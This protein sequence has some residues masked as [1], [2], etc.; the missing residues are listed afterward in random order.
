MAISTISLTNAVSGV[1]PVA[2]GVLLWVIGL[3]SQP[4]G[5]YAPSAILTRTK[6]PPIHSEDILIITLTNA[7]KTSAILLSNARYEWFY[8]SEFPPFKRL[9]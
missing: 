8:F 1:L 6:N 2:N 9:I 7:G 3:L 4:L 5:C